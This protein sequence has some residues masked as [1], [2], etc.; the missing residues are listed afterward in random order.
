MRL[1]PGTRRWLWI[2]AFVVVIAFLVLALRPQPVPVD[3]AVVERGPVQVLVRHEGMTRVRDRFIVSAPLP[4]K[5]LRVALEPGDPV[6]GGETVVAVFRPAEPLLLDARS[7]AEAEA[8]VRAAEAERDRAG[9]EK[10]R[11]AAERDLSRLALERTERLAR[12][13][14][15]SQQALDDARTADRGGAE[16]LAAAEAALRRAESE[17]AVARAALVP[18][19]SASAARE[20]AL[21]APASGTILRRF[22]ESETVLAQGAPIV[23]IADLSSLEIVADFLSTDAVGFSPGMRAIVDGW[24]GDTPL[25]ARVRLVEPQAFMKVSALGV[26]EQRV[27]VVLDPA[28]DGEAWARLGDAFRVQVGVVVADDADALR[29]PASAL[30]RRA[31]AWA[32]FVVEGDQARVRS[33][34]IGNQNGFHASVLSGL[35]AGENVVLHPSDALED[36]M[37]V[38]SRAL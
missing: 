3:M 11:I 38:E 22:Q 21:R 37:R 23:E 1:A 16:A 33:I 5:L 32:V 6:A 19:G 28:G 30:F 31:G 13:G 35:Q 34:E 9:A 14:V 7:R 10:A 36:G 26:E 20:L 2:A 18:P 29:V 17:L 24:G 4:G 15:L 8:R 12:E 27:N 25:E